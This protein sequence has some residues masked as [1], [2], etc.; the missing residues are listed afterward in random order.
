MSPKVI[1]AAPHTMPPRQVLLLDPA[2][3]SHD[4]FAMLPSWNDEVICQRP[5]PTSP[6]I[7][8]ARSPSGKRADRRNSSEEWKLREETAQCVGG[9]KHPPSFALACPSLP[10]RIRIRGSAAFSDSHDSWHSNTET[11]CAA[12]DGARAGDCGGGDPLPGTGAEFPSG[13]ISRTCYGTRW[14]SGC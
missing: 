5:S 1:S 13:E 9:F 8:A 12:R 6:A 11:L 7:S 14:R 4:A 10:C 3:G 2:S